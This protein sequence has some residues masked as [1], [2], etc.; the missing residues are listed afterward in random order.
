M[1]RDD[2]ATLLHC[3]KHLCGLLLARAGY[4][5]ITGSQELVA[6]MGP[7][8]QPLGGS[9]TTKGS[10]LYKGSLGDR[11][12]THVVFLPQNSPISSTDL[13]QDFGLSSERVAGVGRD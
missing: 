11:H 5:K 9:Y 2:D 8:G 4:H 6:S 13:V 3:I 1:G 12:N 7:E 10:S